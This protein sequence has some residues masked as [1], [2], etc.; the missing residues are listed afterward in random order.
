MSED[1]YRQRLCTHGEV[2]PH[3]APDPNGYLST[4]RCS[5]A[6]YQLV[7]ADYEIAVEHSG[8]IGA[9]TGA[10]PFHEPKT[11]WDTGMEPGIYKLFRI[12]KAV[13]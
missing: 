4:Y 9:L 8:E 1:L 6:W 7:N 10:L 3:R 13:E 11:D 2:R 12:W 5:G